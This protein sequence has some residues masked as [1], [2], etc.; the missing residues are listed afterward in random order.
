M[1][2]TKM[3]S[4]LNLIFV[5]LDYGN[6]SDNSGNEHIGLYLK[7]LDSEKVNFD[8]NFDLIIL[9]LVD[10][11]KRKL[12]TLTR[13][14]S[15][16]KE[17]T[18]LGWGEKLLSHAELTSANS[19]FTRNGKMNFIATIREH[20]IEEEGNDIQSTFE[21]FF[22]SVVEKKVEMVTFKCPDGVEL[23]ALKKVISAKSAVFRTMF[24]VK[25][26]ESRESEVNIIDFDSA[27]MSELLKFI[28]VGRVGAIDQIDL[29]LYEAAK[30]YMV[31]GLKEI[32][33]ESMNKRVNFANV[34]EMI[35][36]AN[37]HDD[38]VLYEQCS[39]LIYR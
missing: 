19:N 4:Q 8:V 39:L 5:F 31:E 12:V 20:S 29:K 18:K 15:E 36:F 16:W 11:E 38:A 2:I 30:V 33:V 13:L 37:F 21:E 9:N 23:N 35:E 7:P 28:Y 14:S 10:Y 27:V 26:K 1:K 34:V 17:E 6:L 22:P 3:F 24:T 25:L 32:C